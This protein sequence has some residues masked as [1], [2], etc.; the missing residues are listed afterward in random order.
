VERT[1]NGFVVVGCVEIKYK[2]FPRDEL[3][4][5]VCFKDVRWQSNQ[6]MLELL[7]IR[8]GLAAG[9]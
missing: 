1:L 7:H 8:R 4:V 5:F 9:L 6:C 2:T 3:K